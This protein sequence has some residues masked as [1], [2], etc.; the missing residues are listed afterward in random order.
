MS[1]EGEKYNCD[2]ENK[3]TGVNQSFPS[4]KIKTM[5]NS[6]MVILILNTS[7]KII[8]IILGGK[9]CHITKKVITMILKT[10]I[11][12]TLNRFHF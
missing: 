2:N 12:N 4:K 6:L 5:K 10:K 7:K 1:H 9:L 8:N 11:Y 3:E